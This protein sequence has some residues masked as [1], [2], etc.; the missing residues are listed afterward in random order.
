MTTESCH[1]AKRSVQTLWDDQI[2]P[3]KY[4]TGRS[5]QS[6]ILDGGSESLPQAN[7]G[8]LKGRYRSFPPGDYTYPFEFLVHD[9]LPESI[10]TGLISTRYYV[11]ATIELPRLFRSKMR[12]QLDVPLLRLPSENSL[13]LIEPILSTKDWHEQ[14]RY[15]ACILGRSFRLGSRIPIRLKLTPLANLEC[16][17]IQVHVSQ[18]VQYL[19]TDR[20]PHRLQLPAKRVLLFQKQAGIA[21]YSTYPGSRVQV[22]SGSGTGRPIGMQKP[23]LLGR[24]LETSEVELEVQLPRCPE[25]EVK[26]QQQRLQPSAKGGR[27]EVSHWVQVKE[28]RNRALYIEHLPANSRNRLPCAFQMRIKMRRPQ[29]IRRLRDF[30]SS[31]HQ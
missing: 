11:E 14:L 13:E 23:K 27:F 17:W 6:G 1:H 4:D 18:H 16:H 7:N 26:Q 21:S 8:E 10:D 24:I 29:A 9:F 22:T 19:R 20:E 15:N 3:P 5:D 12:S 30:W 28:P 2:L 25:I 31:N